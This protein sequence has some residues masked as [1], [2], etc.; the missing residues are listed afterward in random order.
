VADLLPHL[1]AHIARWRLALDGAPF[2]THSSWL[3]PVRYGDKPALLKV[4]KPNSDETASATILRH[5]GERAVRVFEG[6]AAAIVIERITPAAPLSDLVATDDDRATHLWCDVVEALHIR[7]APAGW[8]D[9]VRCGRSLLEKPCPTHVRLPRELF[10]RARDEFRALCDSQS[11]TRYLLHTDL[12]P[13]NVLRDAARGW[14]VIDP[15]GYAGELAFETASF[16]H[17]PTRDFCRPKPLTRRVHILAERLKLEPERL[18]RWCFAHG[19]LS[20]VWSI[21]EPVFD[22]VGGIEAANAALEVLGFAGGR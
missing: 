9:L 7:P 12:H 4:F 19:V 2:E 5:W 15:K 8:K 11:P 16:L 21:E 10:E 1:R 3:A 6:D 22:P 18:L 17:N 20:A 13:A 14:L